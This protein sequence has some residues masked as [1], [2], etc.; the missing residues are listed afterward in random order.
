V[1]LAHFLPDPE[2][3]AAPLEHRSFDW[4]SRTLRALTLLVTFPALRLFD[5]FLGHAR[6]FPVGGP[7]RRLCAGRVAMRR[8][9]ACR[10]RHVDGLVD[11]VLLAFLGVLH[12]VSSMLKLHLENCDRLARFRYEMSGATGGAPLFRVPREE[13]GSL[14][15]E[16]EPGGSSSFRSDKRASG[17]LVPAG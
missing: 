6:G 2:S 5:L 16:D 12:D 8:R 7:T 1:L 11:L 3:A 10:K 9:I 4:T 13:G 14:A 17:Q 15:L